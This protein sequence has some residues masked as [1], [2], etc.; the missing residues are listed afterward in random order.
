[1]IFDEEGLPKLAPQ[2]LMDDF[3][4]MVFD[5]MGNPYLVNDLGEFTDDMGNLIPVNPETGLPY[6]PGTEPKEDDDAD[7]K[8]KKG[9]KGKKGKKKEDESDDDT[10]V[11]LAGVGCVCCIIFVFIALLVAY[12]Q[13]F[14]G[15]E[16]PKP[17]P[18]ESTTTQ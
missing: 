3:G 17:R 16:D 15:G 1:M 14:I 9:K 8:K 11:V 2:P 4:E 12:S 7:K 5:E 10:T 13:G 6:L 18:G